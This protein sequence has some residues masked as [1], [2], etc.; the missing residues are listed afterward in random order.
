MLRRPFPTPSLIIDSPTARAK[1]RREFKEAVREAVG[2]FGGAEVAKILHEI[3][4]S[5]RGNTPD[6]ERNARILAEWDAAGSVTQETFARNFCQKYPLKH[7]A[8]KRGA[9]RRENAGAVLKQLQR[10]LKARQ[11]QA[12]EKARRDRRLQAA[13]QRKNLPGRQN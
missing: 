3:T 10:L 2:Y 8:N 1:A 4:I 13:L 9:A 11:Q 6:E 5:Q 7:K 12:E